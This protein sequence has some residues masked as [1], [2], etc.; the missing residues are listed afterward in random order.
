MMPELFDL[1]LTLGVGG[2][3]GL[4]GSFSSIS[5]VF[6][7]V[8]SDFGETC[9]AHVTRLKKKVTLCLTLGCTSNIFVLFKV[10]KP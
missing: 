3:F 5:P 4:D 1:S 2:S 6:V 9:V 7:I 10:G 8:L